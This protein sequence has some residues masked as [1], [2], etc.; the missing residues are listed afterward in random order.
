MD[1]T[2][3]VR[4]LASGAIVAAV[5]AAG[6]ARAADP[7]GW[8]FAYGEIKTCA[9]GPTVCPGGPTKITS[10]SDFDANHNASILLGPADYAAIT[11]HDY[12]TV[13]ASAA[14]GSGGL[15]P[16]PELK[17]YTSGTVVAADSAYSWNFASAQG[18]E[19]FKNISSSALEIPID[20]FVG[21]VDY[22]Y[23]GGI[24]FNALVSASLALLGPELLGDDTLGNAWWKYS[25]T[26]GFTGQFAADCSTGGAIALANPMQT[27]IDPGSGSIGV[28]PSSC[29][30][31]G[32]DSYSL[33]PGD[34]I[35]LWAR[36]STFQAA[37]GVIDAS[38]T[39]K[40]D[41]NPT[42]DSTIRDTL[43]KDLV[44]VATGSISTGAPE[45]G[46]WALMLTGVFAVGARLR[47][48]RAAFA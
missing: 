35:F 15:I 20:A 16:L 10:T 24:K 34:T 44:V 5:L 37:S 45:P 13:A 22:N 32:A 31:G 3:K 7:L 18:V 9:F 1:R 4:A 8:S 14:P 6:S 48:R 19:A 41:F 43:V 25:S 2:A 26:P 28:T 17:S 39:F 29:L 30:A 27:F 21:S 23:S 47:R 42:L 33:A 36:L 38:H 46:L 12:G 11:P 40:V